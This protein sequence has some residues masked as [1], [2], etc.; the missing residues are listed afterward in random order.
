MALSTD[1][2]HAPATRFYPGGLRE[3]FDLA[4]PVVL[5]QLSATTM[6]VVDSAMVG[7]LGATQL[8]SVGFGAIAGLET[9]RENNRKG[10]R[11]DT[12]LSCSRV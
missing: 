5:T 9:Q 10:W 8:A 4:V 7:R 11:L 6:G 1:T 2:S 3:V 12:T